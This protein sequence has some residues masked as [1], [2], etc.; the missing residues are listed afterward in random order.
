MHATPG[1]MKS[2]KSS[3]D[4]MAL[5][6]L[7]RQSINQSESIRVGWSY[8]F[9]LLVLFYSQLMVAISARENHS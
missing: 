2:F 5:M 1:D 3:A 8:L 9:G 4:N 6:V 7:L